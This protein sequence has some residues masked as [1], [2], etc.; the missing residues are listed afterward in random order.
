MEISDDLCVSGASHGAFTPFFSA[1]ATE[2]S[3]LNFL[4][5]V[6][7]FLRLSPRLFAPGR[8]VCSFRDS[9][10]LR[11]FEGASSISQTL[12]LIAFLRHTAS[13][14]TSIS[15]GRSLPSVRSPRSPACFDRPGLSPLILA[16]YGAA[17]LPEISIRERVA[18]VCLIWHGARLTGPK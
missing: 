10:R 12:L 15:L 18:T 7:L 16:R 5:V 9:G 1:P 2:G 6:A 17:R 8:S 13:R 11:D 4:L 14:S 3:R